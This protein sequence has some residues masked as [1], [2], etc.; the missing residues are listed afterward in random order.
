MMKKLLPF[1]IFLLF[2]SFV[3]GQVTVTNATFPVT[4]D[5][6]R[7]ATD[8]TPSNIE[9]TAAG[10]PFD[11]DFTSLSVGTQAEAV[12]LDA[13]EGNVFNEI[14]NATH[15]VVDELLGG[16]SY[17]RVSS[18]QVEFLAANGEDPAGFGIG[19]I[20][21]F[22]PPIVQRRAPM[23]FPSNNSTT[24]SL[25]IGFAWDSL[26]PILTDSIPLP[27]TPDSI[28]LNIV[29]ER[30]DFVDAYGTLSIPGG[31]YDV[32]REKRTTYTETRVEAKVPL[33]GWQDVTDL[34]GGFGGIGM[35]T[36]ITYDYFSNT[37][38]EVIATVTVD[39][40]DNATSV[41]F[42]DNGLLSSDETVL[43]DQPTV[44]VTPNPTNDIAYFNFDHFQDANY[45]LVIYNL[46][47]APVHSGQLS[48][49]GQ[50]SK[51]INISLLPAG[52]YFYLL[53]NENGA[54]VFSGKLIKF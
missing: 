37:E 35:D 14:P 15:V 13:S 39:V 33:F 20:F 50:Q 52:P 8:L 34:L 53:K 32:L 18:D 27:I 54:I 4:G 28:R 26:P 23:M 25:F 51:S 24:S 43:E 36:T 44:M 47:G 49:I 16:E 29:N 19:A 7:T 2:A 42:K 41:T 10:G 31:T 9:I 21:R 17:F 12:F 46:S 6:L 38:K 5:T 45:D 3:I 11:W 22:T 48:V 1:C 40:N 30:N